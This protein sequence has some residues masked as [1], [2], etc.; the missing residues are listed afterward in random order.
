M[1]RRHRIRRGI[2][3]LVAPAVSLLV[4]AQAT[5]Q[6]LVLSLGSFGGPLEAS[7]RGDVFDVSGCVVMGFPL[8]TPYA[9]VALIGVGV[10]LVFGRRERPGAL[11][12]LS[13]TLVYLMLTGPV[14]RFT[15]GL[16]WLAALAADGSTR[17][18]AFEAAA[19]GVLFTVVGATTTLLLFGWRLPR[20]ARS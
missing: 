10:G 3:A 4:G 2:A 13:G 6:A 1:A 20:L 15:E 17:R 16:Q 5:T 12:L 11:F 9:V 7:L 19:V 18:V 14:Y 8:F